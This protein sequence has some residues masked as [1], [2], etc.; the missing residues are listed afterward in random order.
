MDLLKKRDTKAFHEMR[1]TLNERSL[2]IRIL[3][4][5]IEDHKTSIYI[6]TS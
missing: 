3:E 5:D 1:G 6:C 4:R 2:V